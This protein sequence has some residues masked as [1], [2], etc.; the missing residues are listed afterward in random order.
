MGYKQ[1]NGRERQLVGGGEEREREHTIRI[2]PNQL[3]GK[4]YTV[5]QTAELGNIY[6]ILSFS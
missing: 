1:S 4:K 3:F 6:P 5:F 2:H